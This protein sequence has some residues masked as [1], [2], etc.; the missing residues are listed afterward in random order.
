VGLGVLARVQAGFR[1]SEIFFTYRNLPGVV[2]A[3]SILRGPF[4]ARGIYFNPCPACLRCRCLPSSREGDRNFVQLWVGLLS[5][6][7]L[8]ST[9]ISLALVGRVRGHLPTRYPRLRG[10]ECPRHTSTFA[11]V[12][13][14]AHS[15]VHYHPQR[16]K[17]KQYR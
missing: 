9:S 7:P 13:E 5:D 4:P 17:H 11:S 10:Q 3:L 16:K 1:N 15:D 6:K 8:T 12:H 14:A 2:T